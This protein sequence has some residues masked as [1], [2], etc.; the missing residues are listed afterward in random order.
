MEIDFDKSVHALCKE[1]EKIKDLLYE[2]GFVEIVKPAMLNTVGRIMT[3]RKGAKMRNIDLEQVKI[4]FK[5]NGYTIKG[6]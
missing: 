2:M 1:D 5:E 6:E 3:L 4:K